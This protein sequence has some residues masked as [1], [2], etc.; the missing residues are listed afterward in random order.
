MASDNNHTNIDDLL[1]P[2][3]ESY[4]SFVSEVGR[5][6]ARASLATMD[7]AR[8]SIVELNNESEGVRTPRPQDSAQ[9]SFDDLKDDDVTGS[10]TNGTSNTLPEATTPTITNATD[11]GHDRKLSKEGQEVLQSRF[12]R[13][14]LVEKQEDTPDETEID[15]GMFLALCNFPI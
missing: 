2:T 13:I 5:V 15:W 14:Q 10:A 9:S 12:E 4:E 7:D 8:Y 6:S 1:S 3:S 11:L